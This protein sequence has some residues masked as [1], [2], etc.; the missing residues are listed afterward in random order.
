LEAGNGAANEPGAPISVEPV[1]S[2]QLPWSQWPLH[3]I[4]HPRRL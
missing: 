3:P 2:R 1:D 4:H